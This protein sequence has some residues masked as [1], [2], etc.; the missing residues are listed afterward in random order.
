MP[1]VCSRLKLEL[2]GVRAEAGTRTTARQRRQRVF[3]VASVSKLSPQRLQVMVV[4]APIIAPGCAIERRP[5]V[6]WH[7]VLNVVLVSAARPD[8]EVHLIRYALVERA[9]RLDA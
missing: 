2:L 7:E 3:V 1:S 6:K 9:L 5:S 4:T 8:N